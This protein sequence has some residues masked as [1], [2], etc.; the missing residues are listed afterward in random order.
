[1]PI[2][3]VPDLALAAAN[4]AFWVISFLIAG[5]VAARTPLDRLQA[6]G[7]VLRLRRFEQD[8]RWYERRLRIG[9][10]KDRLPEAGQ[11]LGGELSK[12]HLPAERDGGLVRYAAETRRAERA[13]WSSLLGLPLVVLWNPLAGAAV[14]VAFGLAFNAPFVAVQRYNRA[15]IERILR[16]RAERTSPTS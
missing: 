11:V 1:M 6:D 10:W 4:V 2:V 8:G 3:E 15:R 12:R 7:P 5:T 14:M 16:R 13:H 9:R